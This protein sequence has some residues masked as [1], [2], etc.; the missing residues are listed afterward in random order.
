MQSSNR[1]LVQLQTPRQR[2]KYHVA[3]SV[4]EV[5]AVSCALGVDGEKLDLPGVPTSH[6]VRIIQRLNLRVAT[7]N[8]RKLFLKLINNKRVRMLVFLQ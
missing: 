6:C 2:Q 4:L 1:L 5:E 7:L 8:L 3:A